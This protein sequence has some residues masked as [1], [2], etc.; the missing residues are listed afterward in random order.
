MARRSQDLAARTW[1]IAATLFGC[2]GVAFGTWA[3]LA[4]PPGDTPGGSDPSTGDPPT[5][6]S[7]RAGASSD[8]GSEPSVTARLQRCEAELERLRERKD[9]DADASGAAE[10]SSDA[11]TP[12]TK[13]YGLDPEE[14]VELAGRCELRVD[15]P[16]TLSPSRAEELGMTEA[17]LAAY[18]AARTEAI[19]EMVTSL[20]QIWAE[21]F[22]DA[23]P[24]FPAPIVMVAAPP[25]ELLDPEAAQR[26]AEQIA[27][28][29]AGLAEASPVEGRSAGERWLR[30][31]YGVG[32]AVQAKLGEAIGEARAAELRAAGSGW[33]GGGV[34]RMG[35]PGETG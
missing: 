28:E 26:A 33:P 35:C 17:E 13:Y 14:L 23:L 6:G 1:V 8:P 31:C 25:E 29:R 5:V 30:V 11:A 34:T 15:W 27:T 24:T 18:E 9:A 21:Q 2:G 10:P 32:D 12:A 4:H 16:G 7:P 3:M 19:D 20:E 22:D